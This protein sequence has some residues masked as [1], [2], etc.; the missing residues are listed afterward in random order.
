MFSG[1]AYMR[2]VPGVVVLVGGRFKEKK[3]DL[4][5]HNPGKDGRGLRL[6]LSFMDEHAH[7]HTHTHTHRGAPLR[8]PGSTC[9]AV[10]G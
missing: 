10:L 3:V 1:T 9:G 5:G 7:T 2:H 6:E 8:W 4:A